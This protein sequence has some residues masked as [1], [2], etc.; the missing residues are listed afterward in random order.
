MIAEIPQALAALLVTLTA[1]PT[2]GAVRTSSCDR[3]PGSGN[4][5]ERPSQVSGGPVR[6]DR[7]HRGE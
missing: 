6:P 3:L 5:R 4:T 2:D 7:S 1:H